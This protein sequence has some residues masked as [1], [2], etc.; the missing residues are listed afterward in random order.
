MNKE[1][2]ELLESKAKLALGLRA[3]GIC[4]EHELDLEWGVEHGLFT[5]ADVK[6]LIESLV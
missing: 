1:E 5:R 6:C 4:Y 3:V 2:L